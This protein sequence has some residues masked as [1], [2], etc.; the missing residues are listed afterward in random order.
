M[1]SDS[2]SSIS[3]FW[4]CEMWKYPDS[5]LFSR[6][7]SSLSW[8]F[9]FKWSTI[10]PYNFIE[11]LRF[12]ILLSHSCLVLCGEIKLYRAAL[13]TFEEGAIPT[14]CGFK[15][16]NSKSLWESSRLHAYFFR[17]F[18]VVWVCLAFSFSISLRLIV[19]ITKGLQ[20]IFLNAL[21]LNLDLIFSAS[22]CLKI[23]S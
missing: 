19:L 6:I 20:N 5:F 21:Q 18:S 2:F 11:L 3:S 14:K 8:V 4:K 17:L 12:C 23:S 9:Y 7:H 10:F 1:V 16:M 22:S 15:R 13:V